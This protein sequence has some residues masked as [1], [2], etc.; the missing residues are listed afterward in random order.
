ML[1]MIRSPW[2]TLRAFSGSR[3]SRASTA[4][5][6]AASRLAG[7]GEQPDLHMVQLVVKMTV[8]VERHPNLPGD[9][10][11]GP[12]LGRAGENAVGLPELDQLPA[13]EERGKVGDPGRL[14]HVVG[15]DHDRVIPLQLE[16]QLLDALGRHRV[17]GG[18]GLVHQ[19][20]LGLVA[21]RAGDAEPLLLAAGEAGGHVI[22]PVL[23]LVPKGGPPETPFDQVGKVPLGDQRVQRRP[24]R[25]VVEHRLGERVGALEHHA[26]PL[27]QRDLRRCRKR[28]STCRPA[29]YLRYCACPE[30]VRSYRLIDR[31]NVDLPQPEGPMIAVTARACILRLMPFSVA[32]GPPYQNLKSR[33]R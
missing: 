23:D 16:D 12:F 33:T 28:R 29:G 26:D 32:W 25:H 17:E 31:R 15:H 27:P 6:S 22:E 21:Q 4:S 13:I 9:V 19:Q 10:G 20:H 24:V 30:S 11:L 2:I 1:S 3:S 18:A 5:P 8:A 7:H 14:L